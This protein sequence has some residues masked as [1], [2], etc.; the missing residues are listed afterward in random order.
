MISSH[1]YV[2]IRTAYR[3]KAGL[4]ACL[5]FCLPLLLVL[6]IWLAQAPALAQSRGFGASSGGALGGLLEQLQTLQGTGA[7]D[8]LEGRAPSN[9]NAARQAGSNAIEKF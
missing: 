3:I 7:I 2:N 6:S 4:L 8:A 1:D 5:G 9:L